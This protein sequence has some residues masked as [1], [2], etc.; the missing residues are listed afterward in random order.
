MGNAA[1]RTNA[2]SQGRLATLADWLRQV[3]PWVREGRR[4]EYP[5]GADGMGGGLR[6]HERK[7]CRARQ[8]VA[9]KKKTQSSWVGL[10]SHQDRGN[11]P[12]LDKD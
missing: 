5:R 6:A 1:G 9:K 12:G 3:S 7:H 8:G 10:F 4:G 11:Q 2:E